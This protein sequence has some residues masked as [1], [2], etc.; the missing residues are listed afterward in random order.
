M[1]FKR[2]QL[3]T[4]KKRVSEKRKFIQVIIGP[5]QVGKTTLVN[6]LLEEI[7]IPNYYVSTDAALNTNSVWIEQQWQTA[8]LLQEQSKKQEFLFIIDEIQKIQN[9][10]EEIKK[11]WDEDIRKKVNIKLVILGSSSLLIQKGLTE[12][13]A[14]R[15]ELI[16][17]GHWSYTEMNKAF[18]WNSNQFIWFGGYPGSAELINDEYRWKNYINESLI[19]TSISKDILLMTRVDKPALMKQL[20]SLGC[21]YSGQIL[22]FNKILGQLHDAGNTTTLSHYLNLLNN[23]GML[24]GLEKFTSR[25]V[26]IKSSSPKF[27]VHNTAFLSSI[28]NEGFEEILEKPEKWGRVVES[29]I[30]AHLLNSSIIKDIKLFYWRQGNDEVD[31]VIKRKGRII[32]IEV[33][34]Q[35]LNNIPSFNIFKQKYNPHKILLI[36]ES[37]LRVEEFLKINPVDLF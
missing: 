16:R 9:W 30:G 6:Q 21:S 34:S 31:F 3:Q 27:Q 32:A 11:L 35:S 12:S 26:R 15:F 13:L 18:G 8:R 36:G 33:K 25:K 37:G 19:E 28:M 10:S 1:K 22:S 4:L 17:L 29:S 7:K 24:A 14:G 5:R 23:A 20:F 2:D